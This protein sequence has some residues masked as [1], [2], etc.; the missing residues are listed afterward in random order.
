MN[1]YELSFFRLALQCHTK[2]L[3]LSWL[4]CTIPSPNSVPLATVNV[5][6]RVPIHFLYRGT[7]F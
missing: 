4:K 2:G 3:K 7:D 1:S 5:N 6:S